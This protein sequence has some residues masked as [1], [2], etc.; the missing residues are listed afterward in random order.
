MSLLFDTNTDNIGF[1]LKRIYSERELDE[2]AT[3]EDSSVAQL[4]GLRHVT[5]YAAQAP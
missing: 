3:T 2:E 1:H 5:K 4:E